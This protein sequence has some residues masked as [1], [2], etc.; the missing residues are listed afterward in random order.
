MEDI[1]SLKEK[2]L[3][4]YKDGNYQAAARYWREAVEMLSDIADGDDEA[5]EAMASLDWE[6]ERSLYLNLGMAHLKCHEPRE[7]LRALKCILLSGEDEPEI[8]LKTL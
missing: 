6:L 2:G 5:A 3:A 1:K 8:M 7:A 4:E